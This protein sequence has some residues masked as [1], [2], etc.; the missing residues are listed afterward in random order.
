MAKKMIVIGGGII[1][2]STAMQLSQR[3]PDLSISV[4]E[5]EP[6]LAAHQT[7]HNSGVIHAGVNYAPGSLKA[8]FCKEGSQA[9]IDFCK[10]H[11]IPFEQCG[12]LIVATDT[13]GMERLAA[14]Y[15][16]CVSNGL[17]PEILE[18]AQLSEREPRVTGKGAIYVSSSGIADYPAIARAMAS[19]VQKSGGTI[20]TS[21]KVLDIR[22]EVD[23]VAVETT[24]GT[25]HA[26]HVVVCGGLHADRLAAMCGIELDFR[27]VPFRGEYYRLP[28]AKNDIVRHLIYPVPDPALPFLGVHLTRMIGGYV[29]VGPN[30]VLALARE[31]YRWGQVNLKD[32]AEMA[33]FPGFWRVLRNHWSSAITEARNSLSVRS[34]LNECRKYCPELTIEDLEPYPSGVRAQAVLNDGTLVHDFMIRN[35]RRTLHVCNAPSPAATSAIPIG[36]YLA[37]RCASAFEMTRPMPVFS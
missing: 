15:E 6:S 32:L 26:D 5:K 36:R 30:A 3:F 12:K 18:A 14:L 10:Q 22:E 7:G 17:S 2:L 24:A 21:A 19:E 20:L 23:S 4:I 29:T 1:G 34:Y 28:A 35:S 11:S 37:E 33:R 13:I 31:G 25:L 16:R 9:T 8:K 27:I